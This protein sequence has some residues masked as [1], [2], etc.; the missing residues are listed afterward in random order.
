M[1]VFCFA[2]ES[3]DPDALLQIRCP[4]CRVPLVLHQPDE[5]SDERMLGVCGTCRSWFL[6]DCVSHAMLRLPDKVCPE[7]GHTRLSSSL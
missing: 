4:E 3:T 6:V 1:A 7:D 5:E 2:W